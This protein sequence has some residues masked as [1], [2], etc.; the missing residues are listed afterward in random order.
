MAERLLVALVLGAAAVGCADGG[1][2]PS[3]S[4]TRPSDAA[5][6]VPLSGTL[7]GT[8]DCLWVDADGSRFALLLPEGSATRTTVD[9]LALLDPNETVV[10]YVGDEIDVVGGSPSD[11][12]LPIDCEG[13]DINVIFRVSAF[14]PDAE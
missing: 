12:A 13:K 14:G 1:E 4:T 3:T 6:L 8:A 7:G 9:G 2:A 11:A 10:A 5:E